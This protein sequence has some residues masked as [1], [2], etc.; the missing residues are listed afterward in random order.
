MKRYYK[1]KTFSNITD[2]PVDCQRIINKDRI[3]V[4]K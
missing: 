3:E 4:E 1:E 2:G